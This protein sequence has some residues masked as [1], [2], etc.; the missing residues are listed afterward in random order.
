M[1]LV[2]VET[3]ARKRQLAAR[4]KP[5]MI[6][7]K[8]YAFILASKSPR[9]RFLLE[10]LGLKF[11]VRTKET[12]ESFPSHL[13]AEQIPLYLCRMKAGAFAGK[14][15]ANELL[16]T[17]DTVVWIK[18]EILNKPHDAAEAYRMLKT[19]SG[20]MH[21]VF[22]GICLMTAEKERTFFT[23]SRIY[24]RKLS[25]AQI[26]GYI[27][28]YEPFDKAGAYGAQESMKPGISPC[29]AR[30]KIFI[31]KLGKTFEDFKDNAV[32]SK[33]RY[34]LVDK[35]E[36]SFFNVMGLPLQELYSELSAF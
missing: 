10:Q 35:I 27:H 1:F 11:E 5:F 3:P 32:Q 30:E 13:K 21:E 29:S 22:T 8:K 15:K 20:N 24:F 12:G 23:G 34:I 33:K 25:D 9:R 31:E 7:N 4:L 28:E 17:A 18:G 16:I 19:L 26:R 36:G 14:L 2:C 6:H